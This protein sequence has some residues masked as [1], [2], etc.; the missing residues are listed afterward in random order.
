M[1]EGDSIETL[2]AHTASQGIH[3]TGKY[4]QKAAH[5]INFTRAGYMGCAAVNL[6]SILLYLGFYFLTFFDNFTIRRIV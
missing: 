5:E 3:S 1:V 2:S 6:G 4:V